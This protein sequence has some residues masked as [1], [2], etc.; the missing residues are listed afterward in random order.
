[1][2]NDS[3]LSFDN[4]NILNPF[5]QIKQTQIPVTFILFIIM[6]INSFIMIIINYR[7]FLIFKPRQ[8]HIEI[9]SE[10]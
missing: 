5:I 10:S 9:L 2:S 3:E 6:F 8:I 4:I 1:M 7:E